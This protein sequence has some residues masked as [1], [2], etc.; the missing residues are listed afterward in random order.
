MEFSSSNTWWT[1]IH[2]GLSSWYDWMQNNICVLEGCRAVSLVI[3]RGGLR[4][5]RSGDLGGL[6]YLFR[7]TFIFLSTG[8]L[9]IVS[10]LWF[11]YQSLSQGMDIWHKRR[12]ATSNVAVCKLL[13][14]YILISPFMRTT[15]PCLPSD[16][17][18]LPSSTLTLPENPT[19]WTLS[20]LAFFYHRPRLNPPCWRLNY[21]LT[22]N[23]LSIPP[24]A[25]QPRYTFPTIPHIPIHHNLTE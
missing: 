25:I 10:N 24:T 9:Y 21:Y 4:L 8:W 2:T 7:F 22:L 16:F 19:I 20:L 6:G 5:L 12:R 14:I 11:L 17:G 15:P 18:S 23:L 13:R 1:S 3:A